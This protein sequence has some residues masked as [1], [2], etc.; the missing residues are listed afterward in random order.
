M[1][2][3][4]LHFLQHFCHSRDHLTRIVPHPPA[5]R[6]LFFRWTR[7]NRDKALWPPQPSITVTTDVFHQ[8][9]QRLG[10]GF[11]QVH[12][13]TSMFWSAERV[14]FHSRPSFRCCATRPCS[15]ART[16][17]ASYI[18]RKGGT[19][20][21]PLNTLVAQMW[22]WCMLDNI[23]LGN[24]LAHPGTGESHSRF[25]KQGAIRR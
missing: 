25:P 15:F 5:I 6:V 16:M 12:D 19:H 8:A 9:S 24:C 11:W 2:P 20:S 17:L 22:V 21:V 23:T 13:C 1:R 3:V 7:L 4:Q 14:S 10:T 18:N